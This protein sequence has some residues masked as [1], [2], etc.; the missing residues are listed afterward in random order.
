MA[1]ALKAHSEPRWHKNKAK[2]SFSGIPPGHLRAC[3]E[4]LNEKS[5]VS[6]ST[7]K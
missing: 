7:E 6:Y 5:R 4:D 3:C 2:I 1:N